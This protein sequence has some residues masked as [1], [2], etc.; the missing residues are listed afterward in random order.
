M[1]EIRTVVIGDGLI[2]SLVRCDSREVILKGLRRSPLPGDV[3]VIDG[4]PWRVVSADD[5]YLLE[6]VTGEDSRQSAL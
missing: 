6:R 2:S 4:E 5:A 1:P 3:F